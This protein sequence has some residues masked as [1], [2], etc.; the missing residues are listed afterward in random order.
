MWASHLISPE[1]VQ[2]K[3]RAHELH[4]FTKTRKDW[5]AIVPEKSGEPKKSVME[6]R[7]Q[8]TL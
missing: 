4:T 6:K 5:D 1:T 7:Q 3:L 2:V 8:N